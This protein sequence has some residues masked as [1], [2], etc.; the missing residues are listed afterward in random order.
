MEAFLSAQNGVANTETVS[1]EAKAK[2]EPENE[3]PNR[4]SEEWSQGADCEMEANR[5]QSMA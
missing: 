3:G 4:S 5:S 1:K 2:A